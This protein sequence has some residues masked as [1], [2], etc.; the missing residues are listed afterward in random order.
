MRGKVDR[1]RVWRSLRGVAPTRIVDDLRDIDLA[2]LH[3]QGKRLILLDVDNTLV[4]WRQ[5]DIPEWVFEWI[6]GGR[7]V[8][9]EFCIL[10]NT[11]RHARL[12]RLS[13]RLDI[14]FLRGRFKP[15]RAMYAMAL[16]QFGVQPEQAIM[17][18]DQLF[19][20]V[21]G[22][23]RSGIDAIWVR[24]M[25]RRDFV[26]TKISRFGER[27]VSTHLRRRLRPEEPSS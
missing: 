8:G 22:A 1:E 20:D 17:L 16:A 13:E 2:A 4:P 21:L 6:A 11:R 18:G 23:N 15:S 12:A 25:T 24:P 14:P 27:I 10:S 5:E 19:T 3:A 7:A 26:G 9:L